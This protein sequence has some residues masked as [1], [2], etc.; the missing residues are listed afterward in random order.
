METGCI[1]ALAYSGADLLHGAARHGRQ[2]V[3]V[4]AVVPDGEAERRSSRCSAGR[5]AAVTETG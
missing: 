4:I 2:P 1:R 5:A 3:P